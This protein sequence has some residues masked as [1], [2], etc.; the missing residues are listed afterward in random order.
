MG[1]FKRTVKSNGAK[2]EY[3]YID[4][5]VNGKRKW[6]SV[7]RVG[8]VTKAAAKKLLAL[9]RTEVLHGKFNIPVNTIAPTFSE[10]AKDYIEYAKVN[11]RS[12]DRDAC[13]LRTLVPVFGSY[14]LADI[15]PFLIEKYKL[16]RKKSVSA[17]TV[18]MELSLLRR[19]FNLGITWDKCLS[20]PVSKVKFYKEEIKGVRVLTK[21]EEERL[22]ESSS[23]HLKTVLITALNTGMRYGEII[24]LCWKDVDLDLGY[25]EVEKSKSG[26]SR[27]IPMNERLK[28]AL[29]I[30]KLTSSVSNSVSTKYSSKRNS[31]LLL[32]SYLSR[33]DGLKSRWAH[34]REGSTPSLPTPVR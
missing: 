5:T 13:S 11:K 19:M 28:E 3:W 27:Q 24:N 23:D 32:D 4:Y 8:D 22:L 25:I 20:N 18:N 29:D 15:S 10:F 26:K 16:E 9:R 21:E 1:V 6:E 12:W 30:L 33:R 31:K 17:R 14:T 34:A 7:G 2:K